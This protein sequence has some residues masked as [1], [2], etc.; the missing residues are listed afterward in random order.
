[1]LP[2]RGNLPLYRE[3]CSPSRKRSMKQPAAVRQRRSEELKEK[4]SAEEKKKTSL[5]N[6]RKKENLKI[7]QEGNL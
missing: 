7:P 3:S 4:M 5:S 1:M 6:K 2:Q